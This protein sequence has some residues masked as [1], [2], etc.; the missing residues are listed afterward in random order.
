MTA[1]EEFLGI[2]PVTFGACGGSDLPTEHPEKC[3]A[4]STNMTGC[5]TSHLAEPGDGGIG[6]ELT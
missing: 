1:N 4:T 5:N 6:Q 3:G 2:S